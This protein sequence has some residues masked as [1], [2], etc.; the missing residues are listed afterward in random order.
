MPARS[1]PATWRSPPRP[2]RRPAGRGLARS[3]QS[4]AAADPAP[5]A[6]TTRRTSGAPLQRSGPASSTDPHPTPHRRA[7]LQHRLQLPH[8]RRGQLARATSGSLRQQRRPATSGQRP[9]PPIRRHPRHPEAPGHLLVAG[10]GLEQVRRRQPHLLPAGPLGRGQPTAIGIPHDPGI[11]PR[12]GRDQPCFT[13]H[14]L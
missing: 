7:R 6:C 4:G 14:W 13:R 3:S 11:E 8:L 12:D 9:P 2:V 5:P 1:P 10:P